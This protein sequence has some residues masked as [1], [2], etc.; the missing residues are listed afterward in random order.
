MVLYKSSVLLMLLLIGI[1]NSDVFNFIFFLIN[2]EEEA[3]VCDCGG[4]TWRCTF[5]FVDLDSV[6][7]VWLQFCYEQVFFFLFLFL[8]LN[9]RA[10]F[11]RSNGYF[12][13][14][15]SFFS[16]LIATRTRPTRT[17]LILVAQ[18]IK[19]QETFTPSSQRLQSVCSANE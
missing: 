17:L 5:L 1:V 8:Q 7:T 12:S 18:S 6:F 15:R 9:E 10:R 4:I 13:C 14:W 3:A 11:N 16:F 19:K 2:N